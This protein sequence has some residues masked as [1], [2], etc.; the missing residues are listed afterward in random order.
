MRLN[1]AGRDHLPKEGGAPW[2]IRDLRSP[3]TGAFSSLPNHRDTPDASQ[4][5]GVPESGNG[6]LA[7]MKLA[8]RTSS[9]GDAIED[10]LKQRERRV[11]PLIARR[12]SEALRA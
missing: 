2:G 7:G 10:A 5:R 9:G 12:L 11:H 1:T 6:R 3:F 4:R 8:V